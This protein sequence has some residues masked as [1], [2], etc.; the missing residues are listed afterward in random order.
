MATLLFWAISIFLLSIISLE[1]QSSLKL[2]GLKHTED[3]VGEGDH[4]VHVFTLTLSHME[5]QGH[6][7]TEK[8]P[9]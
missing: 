3:R 2:Q 4:H 9:H 8:T 7:C 1:E 6:T 5:E